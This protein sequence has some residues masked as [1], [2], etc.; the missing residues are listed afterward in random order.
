MRLLFPM[1]I[2][3]QKHYVYICSTLLSRSSHLPFIPNPVPNA[4]TVSPFNPVPVKKKNEL[5]Q[6]DANS[7]QCDGVHGNGVVASN[8]LKTRTLDPPDSG[9]TWTR[10]GGVHIVIVHVPEGLLLGCRSRRSRRRWVEPHS[11]GKSGPGAS[12]GQRRKEP[13]GADRFASSC[14]LFYPHPFLRQNSPNVR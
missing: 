9:L 14:F 12:A 4:R 11:V 8:K 7:R 2:P 1:H 13:Q 5:D 10:I 3:F 6:I